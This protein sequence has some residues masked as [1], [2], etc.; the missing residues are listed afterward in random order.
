MRK[1]DI[2]GPDATDRGGIMHENIIQAL[3]A[4]AWNADF[5]TVGP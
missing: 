2:L 1:G 5:I 3:A 4:G